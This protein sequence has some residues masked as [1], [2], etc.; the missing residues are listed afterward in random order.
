MILSRPVFKL[1]LLLIVVIGLSSDV[2]AQKSKKS[3][4][5]WY[6]YTEGKNSFN[7]IEPYKDII[8]SLSIF[9]NPSKLFI[10]ACHKNNIEVYIAVG[11][12][13]GNI[14]TPEKRKKT[15][16]SYVENCL[17]H[18]YDG[19]DLDFE[20]LNANVEADYTAF[21]KEVSQKLHKI[22]KKL[23]HCVGF[24]PNIY[25]S[26][27]PE[28]FCKPEVVASTCDLVRVMCYDMYFAPG[29][30]EKSLLQR[31]DCQGVGP[32]ASYPFVK[33]A[34]EFWMKYVST[35]KLVMGMPAYSNDYDLTNGQK[36]MQT[37]ASVPDNVKGALP[38]PNWLGHE[39][40]NSYLYNDST[41]HPHIF[42]ASDAKSTSCLLK[43]AEN[44]KLQ[45]V[46]FWHL[47]TADSTM[48]A[49]TSNWAKGTL[50]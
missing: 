21:L 37:Y 4:H 30:F 13:E 5:T 18:G 12:E 17:K 35:K 6:L 32:T 44:L 34:M 33:D 7:D 26:K 27:T 11:G 10:D 25:E 31:S 48:W 14:N 16:D 38:N 50:Q 20:H 3:V 42:Y 15:T 45:N 46:G 43:L 49:E 22:K 29:R 1:T 24:Y 39:K 40:V 8:K 36:G 23:S 19:V 41:N 9:G 28:L 47:S 2:N